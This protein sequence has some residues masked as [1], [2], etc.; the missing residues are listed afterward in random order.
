MTRA[1]RG[2]RRRVRNLIS[3][4]VLENQSAFDL[5]FFFDFINENKIL[6]GTLP[7]KLS[8]HA[9]GRFYTFVR[10]RDAILFRIDVIVL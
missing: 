5:V 8:E 6:R 3:G 7:E 1:G 9:A 2:F 4:G 10:L